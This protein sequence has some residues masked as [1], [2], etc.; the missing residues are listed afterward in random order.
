MPDARRGLLAEDDVQRV[1]A[2]L[3]V[4]AGNHGGRRA[5]QR[6]QAAAVF[7]DHADWWSTRRPA[8]APM[9]LK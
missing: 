7:A 1:A 3:E 5:D 9:P 2:G 6:E 4:I 8:S